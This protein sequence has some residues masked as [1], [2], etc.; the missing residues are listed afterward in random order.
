MKH[1]AEATPAGRDLRFDSLRGLLLLCMTVNHLPSPLRKLTDQSLG[2]F[3]SAEGFVFISGL[4][5]GMV[6]TRKLRKGG[7][8]ALAGAVRQRINLIYVWHA[9]ALMIALVAVQV[10]EH[11]VGYCSWAAPQLFFQNP[12][13]GAALGL[14][15]LYQPGLFDI[16]PMYCVFVFL[17]PAVLGAVEAGR[18]RWVL[19]LSV[20]AWAAVQF[21]PPL[22][23]APLYPVYIGSFNLFAWQLLF[24]VG[25]ALGHARAVEPAPQMRFNLPVFLLAGGFASYCWG[26]QHLGWRPPWPDWLFGVSLNKPALGALRLADFG[27]VAYLIALAGA[28][29]PRLLTWPPLA[30][31]GQHSLAVVA[32]QSLVVML[33]LQF[34]ALFATPGRTWALTAFSIAFLFASA[35]LHRRLSRKRPAAPGP[36][37]ARQPAPL[38]LS[39][40]HDA[41]AA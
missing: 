27:A 17:L 30:F 9:A 15:L 1:H 39:R 31:L 12:W 3:S 28:A 35:A 34:P 22:Y 14:T 37:G 21:A 20:A 29:W 33:V 8:E 41:R 18:R 19:A 32:G 5:A 11:T 25:A 26:I 16:L 4:V 7:A 10:I 40:P 23:L 13:L 38:A 6:Y 36:V 2:L 24:V